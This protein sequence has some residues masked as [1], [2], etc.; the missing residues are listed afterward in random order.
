MVSKLI[1]LKT[2]ESIIAEQRNWADQHS[3]KYDKAG[4]VSSLKDNLYR[5]LFPETQNEF[6]KGKG[7]ELDGKMQ[8]LHSSSALVVNIFDY[9]RYLGKADIIAQACGVLSR[10]TNI[11]FE[12]TYPIIHIRGTPPH[13]DIEFSLPRSNFISVIE[14]KFTEPY[15]RHTKRVIKEKYFNIPGLWSQ[16]PNCEHLARRIREESR[17]KTSFIYL[18]VPQLLK[19]IL[20]LTWSKSGTQNFEIVYLWYEKHSPEAD[21]HRFEIQQF[22]ELIGAEAHFRAMTYQELFQ[23]IKR[24]VLAD[25]AYMEYIGKRYFS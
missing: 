12:Q 5:P 19:H 10:L 4:Y 8:A 13:L 18:D 20:G 9:W 3:I 22:R 17:S 23:N 1:T 25:E 24:S 7:E 14:S 21:R 16:I 6:R 15:H 2:Y 11:K